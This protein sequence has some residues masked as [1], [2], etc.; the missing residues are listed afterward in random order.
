MLRPAFLALAFLLAAVSAPADDSIRC[1]SYVVDVGSPRAEV[2]AKC[3]A[4][5]DIY[6]R[7]EYRYADDTLRQRILDGRAVTEELLQSGRVVP[8]QIEEWTYN[9]GPSRFVRYLTFENGRLKRIETGS[10]GY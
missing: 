1:G 5:S 4:P 3:G 8:V 9:F 2:R 7:T 6:E 10:Y